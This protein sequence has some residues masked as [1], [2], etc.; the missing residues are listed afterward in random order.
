MGAVLAVL[1]SLVAL[2]LSVVLLHYAFIMQGF[3]GESYRHGM[4]PAHQALNVLGMFLAALPLFVTLWVSWRRFFSDRALE[5]IP[6]GLGLPWAA[7]VVCAGACYLSF[8]AGEGFTSRAREAATQRAR[9]ALRAE[10]EN[11][12]EY[13]ACELVLLDPAATPEDMRRCRALIE[14][15]PTPQAR[16]SEFRNFLSQTSDFRSWNPKQLGLAPAWDWNRSLVAVR[17][18]QEWFLR[19]F[20]EAWLARPAA[21]QSAEELA[22]LRRLLQ[23]S[24]RHS[25]WTPAAVDVLRSQVVPELARHLDSNLERYR[26]DATA[27]LHLE[28][29]RE[30]LETLRT[31]PAE[32]G[33]P[34][35]PKAG[36]VPEGTIG[37]AQ[38]GD[39]ETLRLW[40][41]GTP[42]TGAF[43]DVYLEY[44]HYDEPYR[45]WLSFLGSLPPGE[46][47]PVPPM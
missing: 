13:K 31:K 4:S 28:W 10:V 47:R 35:P 12:A 1:S 40:L 6:L 25:G 29:V 22:N 46:V 9:A 24:T 34:P 41:R 5:G 11:G 30:E 18:D 16:W 15:L 38:L 26:G 14:S 20:Y 36:A 37:L 19:A 2:V 45:K 42:S 7:F 32:G 43:G 17:H 3:A 8:S 27:E 44:R 39:D 23:G 21:L 33:G